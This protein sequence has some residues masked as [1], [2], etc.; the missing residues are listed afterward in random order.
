M[1]F[2]SGAGMGTGPAV[3]RQHAIALEV[4]VLPAPRYFSPIL[5][6]CRHQSVFGSAIVPRRVTKVGGSFSFS[7]GTSSVVA[8]PAWHVASV[9]SKFSQFRQLLP[10][11]GI[12]ERSR[13]LPAKS[14]RG[15]R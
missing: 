12:S 1:I 14:R 13:S 5:A 3:T 4:R 8:G 7:P 9:G 2:R 6:H 10:S 15:A 11:A